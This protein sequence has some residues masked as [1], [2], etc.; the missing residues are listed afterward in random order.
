MHPPWLA[1][2]RKDLADRTTPDQPKPHC[3]SPGVRES[4]GATTRYPVS[5]A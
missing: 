5:S 4:A 1:A 2:L 3:G